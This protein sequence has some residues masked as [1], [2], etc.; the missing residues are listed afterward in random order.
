MRFRAVTTHS[1]STSTSISQNVGC[2]TDSLISFRTQLSNMQESVS[3][4]HDAVM[5]QKTTVDSVLQS[6]SVAPRSHIYATN[7]LPLDQCVL[8]SGALCKCPSH[9][10][11]VS[12]CSLSPKP[13]TPLEASRNFFCRII[14]RRSSG[15]DILSRGHRF[16]RTSGAGRLQ[17]KR[18]QAVSL[19]FIQALAMAHRFHSNTVVV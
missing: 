1:G 5:I 15:S 10:Y 11:A 6:L 13:M 7:E 18:L 8:S 19:R 4:T 17:N 2:S 16:F 12:R 14:Y 3:K 9:Y